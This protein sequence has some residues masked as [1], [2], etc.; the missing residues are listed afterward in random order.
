MLGDSFLRPRPP[1]EAY[2]TDVAAAPDMA[3]F[4]PDDAGWV[5]LAELLVRRARVVAASGDV[6]RVEADGGGALDRSLEQVLDRIVAASRQETAPER[7]EIPPAPASAVAAPVPA[8]LPE[9]WE[10][11]I[12]DAVLPLADAMEEAGALHLA[13]AVLEALGRALPTLDPRRRGLTLA[14]R[15]RTARMVGA[16]DTARD[17]Y[18]MVGDIGRTS[19]DSDLVVRSLLGRAV[20]AR[21]RGN[22]PETRALYRRALR[23]AERGGARA[24]AGLAHHGLLTAASVAGDAHTALVHGWRAYELLRDDP[25]RQADLLATL[26]AAGHDAGYYGA[27]IG[28]YVGAARRAPVP[29]VRLPA[30]AGAAVCAARLGDAPRVAELTRDVEADLA[31]AAR[32]YERAQALTL[33]AEAWAV[34]DPATHGE[35]YLTRALQLAQTYGF[36]E[37]ALQAEQAGAGASPPATSG[38]PI[39]ERR[40]APA[41]VRR[42]LREL[43]HLDGGDIAGPAH[44][45]ASGC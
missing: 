1:L 21:R 12:A 37:L 33:L 30:L 40:A 8:S 26:G 14:A 7:S 42:V 19:G 41:P 4:G 35:P 44:V 10:C 9:C 11:Q 18:D 13:Y 24:L 27:A 29:R 20:L 32:P 5:L 17:L 15:A 25:S 31:S 38:P 28:A 43:E 3:A 2:R 34:H 36:H 16:V 23:L 22:Y 39:D 6:E 45:A